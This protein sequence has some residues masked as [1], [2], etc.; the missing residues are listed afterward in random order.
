M[1]LWP[2]KHIF[3]SLPCLP[4]SAMDT[5]TQ[6]NFEISRIAKTLQWASHNSVAIKLSLYLTES[7]ASKKLPQMDSFII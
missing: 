1:D 3:F 4:Q 2:S 6:Q 7:F 5:L